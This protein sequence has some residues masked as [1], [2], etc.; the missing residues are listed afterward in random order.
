MSQT[1]FEP[2]NVSRASAQEFNLFVG[3]LAEQT[4]VSMS[5][6]VVRGAL[7]GPTA[8]VTACVHGDEVNGLEIVRQVKRNI[9]PH[10][11]R[12]TLLLVPVV[13][14]FG[15]IFRSRYLPD[16]RDL[17]RSFPGS[18]RGSQAAQLARIVLDEVVARSNFGIDLH[19]GP[20]GRFNLPQAW[21]DLSDAT[22]RAMG[23]AFGAPV[24]LHAPSKEGT[25]RHAANHMG[26]PTILFEGGEAMRFDTDS[27][28]TGTEGV[29]RVLQ[30]LGMLDDAPAGIPSAIIENTRWVRARRAGAFRTGLVSGQT[31]EE[32]G[33]LGA[34]SDPLGHET[35]R[36]RSKVGGLVLSH[37][38]SPL[39]NRGDAIFRIGY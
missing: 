34:I 5:V 20:L 7:D 17:N 6:Q 38:T 10:K 33:R 2:E 39:V 28:R 8:F 27:I 30:H 16:R 29:L 23:T 15:F 1:S 13:N 4:E 3:R 21:C 9:D 32:N 31:V 35:F 24:L 37:G 18:E 25:L 19:T 11:L 14:V 22:S 36:I 26:V 12:G